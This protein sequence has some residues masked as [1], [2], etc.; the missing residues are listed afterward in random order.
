[1]NPLTVQMN[2]HTLPIPCSHEAKTLHSQNKSLE[3]AGP[4]VSNHS[5]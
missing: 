4:K 5:L 3:E 2:H 1:M